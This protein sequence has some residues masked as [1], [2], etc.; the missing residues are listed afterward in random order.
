MTDQEDIARDLVQRA[1]AAE[2]RPDF[3]VEAG[4][5][6][7][8]ARATVLQLTAGDV[9]GPIELPVGIAVSDLDGRVVTVNRAFADI[10]D[11][12]PEDIVGTALVELLHSEDDPTLVTAY[13][14]LLRGDVTHFR[15]HG[16][17][18]V[19]DGQVV[20]AF[21]EGSLLRDPDGL[22]TH[23]AIIVEDSTDL[24]LLQQSLSHQTLH[25]ML[26]G[27]PNEHYFM[28]YLHNVLEGADPSTLVTVC[29]INLDN[30]TVINDGIG[31]WA[32]EQ[33]LCSVARRLQ[34]LV[35]EERAM[36]ARIGGD[37]FAI[38][39]ENGMESRDLGLFA[40]DINIRLSEPVYIDHRGISVSAGV[41]VVQRRAGGITAGKLIRGADTA[42][43]QAKRRGC[44]HWGLY[45]PQADA[46]EREHYQLAV[47]MPGAWENG[48]ITVRYQPVH[49]L[50]DGRIVALHALLHWDRSD[51]TVVDHAVCLRLAELT[52]LLV[53]LGPW[54]VHESCSQQ[55]AVL[56]SLGSEAPL[57]RVDLTPRLSQ[58]PDLVG[59]VRGA[60]SATDLPAEQLWVGV[61]LAALMGDGGDVVDNVGVLTELGTEAVLLGAM[62]GPGYLTYLEDLP[63]SAVEI[64]PDI[65]TRIAQRPGDDSVV[66]QAVRQGIQ[67]VHSVGPTVIVPGVNT[68]EQE[69]WWRS[70]G[71]DTAR[72]AHFGLP[73][74]G[75]ELLR[76][77]DHL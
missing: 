16:L 17:L 43:H 61:P 52:G 59:V 76:L 75:I 14:E 31:R 40:A 54:M 46:R 47:E 50:R 45:D 64:A 20:W 44:G 34:D 6:D 7:V 77:L 70:A 19:A 71:A 24:H 60:L 42:L 3:D 62:A 25:D 1:H 9:R 27:L 69:Q 29:R 28:S 4:V 11:H 65:V 30:F 35:A 41:G 67:L 58:D 13:Q 68:P 21:M 56:G 23:H 5:S 73:V 26:T 38:M 33:L 15:H 2:V 57:M 39:I 10:I 55:S 32:G 22:P 49:W 36:V 63:I 37:D 53:H 18:K 74:Q 48:E 12:C 66:S 8:L 72:G 51:G